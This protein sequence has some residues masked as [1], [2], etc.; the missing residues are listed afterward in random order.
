MNWNLK[1]LI[2]GI[3]AVG[4]AF[5]SA[6]PE[7]IA[8][9]KLAPNYTNTVEPLL[10]HA[11]E[12]AIYS[13]TALFKR[14]DKVYSRRNH[15]APERRKEVERLH[16]SFILA[17]AHLDDAARTRIK[18]IE[19]ELAASPSEW[20]K[21]LKLRH[22]WATMVGYRNA[23]E[24]FVETT[25]L[26]TPEKVRAFLE[27]IRDRLFAV[28]KD[29][30][31]PAPQKPFPDEAKRFFGDCADAL[32][33]NPDCA[34]LASALLE[35]LEAERPGLFD[36]NH[37][38]V[39]RA[40]VDLTLHEATNADLLCD[41]QIGFDPRYEAK[42]F[43][44]LY[45]RV[46]A[47]DL[48]GEFRKK[49]N[50][51][52][53]G[54]AFKFRRNFVEYA[55]T[56]SPLESFRN[57]THR[58]P[59]LAPYLKSLG[60]DETKAVHEGDEPGENNFGVYDY[61]KTEDLA[62]L[63]A[64]PADALFRNPKA[65]IE[66]RIEDVLRYMTP[67]EKMQILHQTSAA[68]AGDIP[69]L[70]LPNFR[71]YDGPNG[72]RCDKP[73]TYF[74]TCIAYAAAFDRELAEAVGRAMGAETRAVVDEKTG[75]IARCLLGPGCDIARSPTGA[76]NYE[77][78][79]EDP[80]LSGEM[81][82]AFCRGLQSVKVAPALKHYVLN[83]QEWCRTCIDVRCGERALREIYERPFAIACRKADVWTIM[84]SY[85]LINGVWASHA[86]EVNDDLRETGWTGAFMPDWG[87][88]HGFT[89]AINGGTSFQTACRKDAE[90]DRELLRDLASGKL[91]K[92]RF[93]AALRETL[94]FFFRVG[95]FDAD[96]DEER[97]LQADCKRLYRSEEH[98]RL[99]YR[100]ASE[101][102][103]LLRNEDAFL[104]LDRKAVRK[105]CVLGPNAD[106]HHT[107]IT[108][109]DLRQ[110]G[111]S[112]AILAGR[113]PT[114]LE[115]A[116]ERFGAANVSTRLEDARTADV[117]FYFGG[118]NHY[119]DREV[120]G[121]AQTPAD[122]SDIRLDHQ[123]L[124]ELQQLAAYTRRV[125]VAITTGAPVQC[126]PWIEGVNA[127]FVTWYAGEEGPAAF[128]DAVFGKVNPSGKLPYTFGYRLADW[129]CHQ[130]GE[131]AFPGV[132]IPKT[133][134]GVRAKEEYADGIFVGYRGF[135]KQK[136][137]PQFPFGFGLSYTDFEISDPVVGEKS[138]RVTVSNIGE[139]RGRAIVQLYVT[140]LA[141]EGEQL[142]EMPEKELATFESVELEPGEIKSVEL[143]YGLEEL[144]YYDER[145]RKW[146]LP[147][148]CRFFVG[149]H[150]SDRA[151]EGLLRYQ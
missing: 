125:V 16:R 52:D 17:G 142:P 70:G 149:Q 80:V 79:G 64:P 147:G 42:Y 94:R 12:R 91:R 88:T 148:A 113:E 89:P 22:E 127:A 109:K 130:L 76:R 32:R 50:C 82:A 136:I 112:G 84:N 145:E 51:Y 138:V 144:Q 33:G 55:L 5:A 146:R 104:P 71:M 29:K 97:A 57:F 20:R 95:A 60:I 59:R 106:F 139:A 150:S 110:C 143:R 19:A 132:L 11:G 39:A 26:R 2:L 134:E 151:V 100:A 131:K 7:A 68:S 137:K 40:I 87:G 46:M 103:V 66:E 90:R 85:N 117:V 63:K 25:D 74:P 56:H 65:P 105:V 14:V 126:D 69:R 53:E 122:R 45:A 62:T 72:V 108:G 38:D 118:F 31:V 141:D 37:E 116:R 99:A 58:E 10:P 18:A 23:A 128:F 61:Q 140:K 48:L 83:D 15:L 102:M 93:E 129:Y 77:Y 121:G 120:L 3:G 34:E 101:S 111:G 13:N 114:P 54:L 36:R 86:G 8:E 30:P 43:T 133:A 75:E 81:A 44:R 124:V 4:A 67:L 123:Q 24:L 135:D 41:V 21:T 9:Q 115:V 6:Q 107:M 49:P 96:S 92:D 28:A 47:E 73:I 98:R 119:S 78:F 1:C 27:E 35:G